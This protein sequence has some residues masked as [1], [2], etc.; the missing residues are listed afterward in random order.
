M[1]ELQG[2]GLEQLSVKPMF[3]LYAP[4]RSETDPPYNIGTIESNFSDGDYTSLMGLLMGGGDGEQAE[5]ETTTIDAQFFDA[6]FI[7]I[8]KLQPYERNITLIKYTLKELDDF[9]N[10]LGTYTAPTATIRESWSP[11]KGAPIIAHEFVWG[12][13]TGKMERIFNGQVT[14]ARTSPSDGAAGYKIKIT[15]LANWNG[16]TYEEVGFTS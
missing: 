10:N 14:F 5:P 4:V 12:Y 2:E 15:A 16:L 11:P 8:P 13:S 6:P 3:L 7:T 9:L 1:A